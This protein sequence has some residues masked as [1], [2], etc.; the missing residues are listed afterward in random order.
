VSHVSAAYDQ[1]GVVFGVYTDDLLIRMYDARNYQEGPF[2]KFSLY[3]QSIL[4]VVEPWL[5]QIKAPNLNTKKMHAIDL[6]FSPDG[7]QLLVTTNRGVF[8]HLDAFEGNLL[9]AFNKHSASQRS[10]L[11]L[12]ASYTADGEYVAT[13]SEDGTVFVYKTKTGE[14]IHTLPKAHHGPI[15]DLRFN[16]QRH[17]LGSVGSN[18]TVLWTPST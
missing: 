2:A 11:K 18:S 15:V 12:G 16:P 10:E 6:Q 3:D 7:N 8:L 9:H 4:N 5:A 14:H 17:L 13:G 1:E